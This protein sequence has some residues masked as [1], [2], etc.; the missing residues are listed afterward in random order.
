VIA[1]LLDASATLT[2]PVGAGA[3]SVTVT[4]RPFPPTIVEDE[5]L[6]FC[7]TSAF[8]LN[9]VVLDAP[10]NVAVIVA[11][12]CAVTDFVWTSNVANVSPAATRTVAGTMTF[13][14]LDVRSTTSPPS[15]AGVVR[16]TRPT[17]LCDPKTVTGET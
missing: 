7:S 11:T 8:T 2:P 10:L 12:A 9:V 13:V 17:A 15:G 5:T 6:R 3:F 16:F 1:A 4:V 14:L